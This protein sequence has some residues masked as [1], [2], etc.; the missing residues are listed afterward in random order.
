LCAFTSDSPSRP[1]TLGSNFNRLWAGSAVS[2]LGD[3]LLRVA[4]PLLI[5]RLTD[6]PAAVAG[7]TLA[8]NGAWLV[9]GLPAGVLSDRLDRRRMAVWGSAIR[10]AL[11]GAI[12]LVAALDLV[13]LPLLY[14]F[15]FALGLGETVTDTAAPALVPALVGRD[16]LQRANARRYGAQLTMNEFAGPSLGG[17]LF[18]LARW[19]PFAIAAA[20]YLLA[21]QVYGLIRGE[22][23]AKRDGETGSLWADARAGVGYLSKSRTV[24]ALAIWSFAANL[25]GAVTFSVLVLHAVHPGPLG[26]TG[27]QYGLVLAALGAGGLGGSLLVER[28]GHRVSAPNLLAVTSIA[29]AM[30]SAAL[31]ATTELLVIVPAL[32][33]GA[34]AAA[35]FSITA[36]SLFQQIVP[37]RLLSRALAGYRMVLLTGTPAGALLAGTVGQITGELRVGFALAALMFVT[38]PALRLAFA[39]EYVE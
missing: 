27:A 20:A 24:R 35:M 12:V 37:D 8:A 14:L 16:Q 7:L 21:A 9:F 31:V 25:A 2:N 5:V 11:V 23:R 1:A 29:M 26:L 30:D 6:S 33:V 22:Y 38:M 19:L 4:L 18:S 39:A 36:T 10:G 13:N 28:L 3:G 32:V 15:A 34:A 17:L